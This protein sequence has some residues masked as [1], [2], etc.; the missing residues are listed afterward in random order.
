MSVSF[1]QLTDA[2]KGYVEEK[3]GNAVHNHSPL[4]KEVDVRMSVRGGE[5]GRGAKLYRCEVNLQNF[6]WTC[7]HIF[8]TNLNVLNFSTIRPFRSNTRINPCCWEHR[9]CL[10]LATAMPE[11]TEG[12]IPSDG[13]DK[14]TSTLCLVAVVWV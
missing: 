14:V 4:V 1:T 3:V 12:P 2:I 9:E 11:V 6:L 5:T 13:Q 10:Q 8:I 7:F